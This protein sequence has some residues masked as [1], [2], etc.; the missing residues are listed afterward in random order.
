MAAVRIRASTDSL[1]IALI[2]VAA[3]GV[4][5]FLAFVVRMVPE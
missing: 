5:L 1:L 3:Y 2:C 4:L